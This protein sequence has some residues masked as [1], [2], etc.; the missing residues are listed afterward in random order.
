MPIRF[1]PTDTCASISL[2]DITSEAFD[3][4]QRDDLAFPTSLP[5][6]MRLFPTDAACAAYLERVRWHG[7]FECPH[8]HEK[9]EPFRFAARPGVLRC[10]KCRKDVALTAGTVMQRTHTPL[11]TWFWG[12]YLVSS[13]TPGMS[14]M[15]FQRQ[16]GLSRY[17]TAFQILHKLRTGMVRQ[18][19]DRIGRKGSHVEIDETWVGGSHRGAGRGVHD[20][21][22]VIAAVEV[23]QRPVKDDDKPM[24]RGGRYAGRLRLEI[25]PDR[26]AASLCGFVEAAVA[27]GAMIVTDGAPSYA[28]LTARG[29]E[30]LP[31][32]EGNDP[33]AAEDYLPIVHLVFSNLKAWL[34]GTHHGAVSPQHLQTYLN[35]FTFRFNRR[36]YPF[37]AFR[38]LLGIGTNGEG[39]T[40]DGLYSGEWKHHTLASR[41]G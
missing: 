19:R 8:C 3:I 12:A 9:G 29:Y 4:H 40:Y 17:E 26:T 38:S 18:D 37:N 20:Q 25:V 22:L 36:F 5:E 30:H 21:T 1:T 11:T 31:V 33:Q 35:E 14:A 34:G 32:V 24:K 27:P 23:R 15:Q 2:M 13:M 16:L 6:F 28:T 41:H 7:A 39:P 10:R